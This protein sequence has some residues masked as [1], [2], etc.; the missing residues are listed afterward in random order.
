MG[1]GSGMEEL[2]ADVT[3]R[4]EV[5][6]GAHLSRD[7]G[8]QIASQLLEVC[9]RWVLHLKSFLCKTFLKGKKKRVLDKMEKQ[10][11]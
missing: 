9:V 6:E 4:E 10:H 3:G 8:V 7:S 5:G 11:L 1:E 2:R